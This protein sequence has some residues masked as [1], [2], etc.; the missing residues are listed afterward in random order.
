MANL[1]TSSPLPLSFSYPS[2]SAQFAFSI[3]RNVIVLASVVSSRGRKTKRKK[4]QQHP[5]DDV[6]SMTALTVEK[7]PRL[8]FMEELMGRARNRDVSRVSEVIYNMIAA[9]LS[10]SPRSFHGLIVSHVLSAD[11]EGAGEV[12]VGKAVVTR[13]GIRQRR[14]QRHRWRV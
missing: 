2:S 4:Q 7:G 1:L 14:R 12:H 11:D 9:G 8:V 6:A 5:N 10:P 13:V 3:S